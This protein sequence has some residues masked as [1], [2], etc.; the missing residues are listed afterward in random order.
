MLL[1][2]YA[3]FSVL[4]AGLMNIVFIVVV[5]VTLVAITTA[6]SFRDLHVEPT[7]WIIPAAVGVL[8]IVGLAFLLSGLLEMIT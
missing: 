3:S 5:A 2:E 1:A 4:Y 8:V 7:Q 6:V